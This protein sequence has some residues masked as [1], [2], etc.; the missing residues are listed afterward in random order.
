MVR[1]A[2]GGALQAG[3]APA[4]HPPPPTGMRRRCGGGR[5]RGREPHSDQHEQR[6]AHV[7]VSVGDAR[8]HPRDPV[9]Y[10]VYCCAPS[11][12]WRSEEGMFI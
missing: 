7:M 1:G 4:P 9:L 11:V 10:V 12:D 2:R 3:E 8:G 6:A 5:G